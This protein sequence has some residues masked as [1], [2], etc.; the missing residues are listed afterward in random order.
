[1]NISIQIVT[2]IAS[3]Q[4]IE[5]LQA[6][7]WGT[8]DLD[9]TPSHVLLIMAKEGGLVMLAQDAAGQP[10]GFSFGLLAL[11]ETGQLKL[12]S[13]MTG[14]LP[15]YQ[16]TGLGYRLKL[17]Q[18]QAALSRGLTLITW[19]FDPLQ[20]RNAY[21]NL[22]KLGA[23]CR[24]YL[25]HLYGDMPDDLNRGMPSDRFRAD[26]WLASDHVARRLS[27]RP[28]ASTPLPSAPLLNPAVI[29][30][31]GLLAS[32]DSFTPPDTPFCQVEVPSDFPALRASDP[33]LA[34]AW[35]LH[36]RAVFEACLARNYTLVNLRRHE[37]RSYYLL[38]KDWSPE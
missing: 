18:R 22:N 34:L 28:A 36:T 21:L 17:A 13:H 38:Q 35:R 32:P 7:I 4:A 23:V 2:D 27:D 10:I 14:V 16:N 15:A 25:R 11:D 1:M 5:Q 3:C 26:W 9:V 29:L 33:G 6:V 20:S 31:N 24:T 37:G 12:A 19:T 8:T 30:P